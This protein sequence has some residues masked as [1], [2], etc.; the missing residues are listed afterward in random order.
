MSFSGSNRL[1]KVAVAVAVLVACTSATFFVDLDFEGSHV[2]VEYLGNADKD[3]KLDPE[4]EEFLNFAL[5]FPE[6]E[7]ILID[8]RKLLDFLKNSRS[9]QDP[10]GK[11]LERDPA[12]SK[13]KINT[14][15]ETFKTTRQNAEAL[16]ANYDRNNSG[17]LESDELIRIGDSWQEVD[18]DRDGNATVDEVQVRFQ[19]YV[20]QVAKEPSKP[21]LAV[22]DS[23]MIKQDR[24]ALSDLP[25]EF[26]QLDADSDGQ[27]EMHEFAKEFDWCAFRK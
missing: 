6:L 19:T 11:A 9:E 23:A 22:S 3:I 17:A 24:Q 25:D 1:I 26:W 15:L 18:F 20:R 7:D 4:D 16:V 21:T 10:W 5:Q 2:D 8:R 14:R 13:I 12:L 27:I